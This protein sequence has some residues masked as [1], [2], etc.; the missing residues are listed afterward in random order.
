MRPT[1]QTPRIAVDRLRPPA[2]DRG[3]PFYRA[4]NAENP[5]YRGRGLGLAIA[6]TIAAAHGGRSNV[7]NVDTGGTRV[8]RGGAPPVTVTRGAQG[9]GE[10]PQRLAPIDVAPAT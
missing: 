7:E 5:R 3:V 1:R 6:R 10:A 8:S 9:Q 4:S 2:G